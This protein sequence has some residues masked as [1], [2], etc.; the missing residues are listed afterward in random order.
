MNALPLTQIKHHPALG[1]SGLI[2]IKRSDWDGWDDNCPVSWKNHSYEYS[3]THICAAHSFN[4]YYFEHH[5][6]H[7]RIC[8]C[9]KRPA[10]KSLCASELLAV[11]FDRQN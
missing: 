5:Y 2:C 7:S 1:P 4:I 11:S 9:T 6:E 10:R 8:R 3:P